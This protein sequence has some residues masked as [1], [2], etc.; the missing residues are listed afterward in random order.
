VP[1]NIKEIPQLGARKQKL[2]E[3]ITTGEEKL[4]KEAEEIR[5]QK[6]LALLK[7]SVGANLGALVS[8]ILFIFFWSAT[9]WTRSPYFS[10]TDT[11]L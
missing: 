5:S 3:F 10:Q 11:E 8:G 1:P 6:R 2:S 7:Q 9:N 4:R